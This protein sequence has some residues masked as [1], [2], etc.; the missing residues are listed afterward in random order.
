MRPVVDAPEFSPLV[1]RRERDETLLTFSEYLALE[2]TSPVKHEFVA[3]RRFAMSGALEAHNVISVNTVVALTTRLR[4][5]PCRVFNSDMMVRIESLDTAYYPDV[6]VECGQGTAPA[7][8][9]HDHPAVIVEVLS[10]STARFDRGAKFEDYR[11]FPSLRS[12][13][14]VSSERRVVELRRIDASGEITT[15]TLHDGDEVVF[16][17]LGIA[18]PVAELYEGSGVEAAPT[19]PQS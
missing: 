1:R 2:E 9:Y 4:G 12:Y 6:H 18:I 15:T 8:R 14:L 10:P 11:A 5:G 13:V 17:E 3:G 7:S 16:S 19:V